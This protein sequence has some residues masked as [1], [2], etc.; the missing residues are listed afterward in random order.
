MRLWA[1]WAWRVE[2]PP[3]PRPGRPRQR[4]ISRGR[5]GVGLCWRDRLAKGPTMHRMRLVPGLA[6]GLTLVLGALTPE[7]VAQPKLPPPTLQRV[8]G[9]SIVGKARVRW[10]RV[11]AGYR[12]AVSI[13]VGA[14]E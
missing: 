12:I 11:S 5:R 8:L 1:V 10:S 4:R 3:A 7:A 9:D 2:G 13:G 6:L 14:A